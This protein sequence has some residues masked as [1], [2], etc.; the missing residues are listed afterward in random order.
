[1]CRDKNIIEVTSGFKIVAHDGGAQSIKVNTN[2]NNHPIIG[3][4]LQSSFTD[5]Q[6]KAIMVD[7]AIDNIN[8]VVNVPLSDLIARNGRE[9]IKLPNAAGVGKDAVCVVTPASTSIVTGFG[10]VSL[11]LY[12]TE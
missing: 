10:V 6:N 8:R 9:F 5:V 2:N 12:S 7:V 1:M 11:V 4:S 3:F